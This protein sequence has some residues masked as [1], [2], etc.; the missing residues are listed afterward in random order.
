LAAWT[1]ETLRFEYIRRTENEDKYRWASASSRYVG[2]SFICQNLLDRK[3]RMNDSNTNVGG[4]DKSAMRE[5]CNGRLYNAFPTVWKS[6]IRQVQIPANTGDGSMTTSMDYIYLPSYVELSGTTISP[7]SG[8][9]SQIGWMNS[10]SARI[11]TID[12]VAN[13][14]YT[15]SASKGY[16]TYFVTVDDLGTIPGRSFVT[17]YTP[18]GIC[19][20]FSIG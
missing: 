8:E 20:C 9:G 4:W 14:Y 7:Y 10:N 11:K 1:H 6:I 12:G 2:A 18:Y 3:Y 15:R 17:S 13:T 16:S 19:P 5:F